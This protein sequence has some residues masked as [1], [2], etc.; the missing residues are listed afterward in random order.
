MISARVRSNSRGL[1][2]WQTIALSV[3]TLVIL[4]TL[5]LFIGT[6][7]NIAVTWPRD[8]VWASAIASLVVMVPAGWIEI[9]F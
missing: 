1:T 4:A 5:L 8:M 7:V 6:S 3:E 2:I 9:V